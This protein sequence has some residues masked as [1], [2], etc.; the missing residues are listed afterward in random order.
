MR[1]MR[2]V[3]VILVAILVLGVGYAAISNVTLVVDG[4]ATATADPNNF[5]VK[6]DQQSTFSAPTKVPTTATVTQRRI[7]DTHATYS[8]TGFTK[9]GETVTMDFPIVNES[10][11]LNASLSAEVTTHNNDEYFTVSQELSS[12][13]AAAGGSSTLS[14]TITVNKTPITQDETV[15][16][17]VTVT[18]TPVNPTN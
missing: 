13:T 1:K 14:V 5:V 17:V 11:T 7:D 15:R 9:A 16:G 2:G 3:L 4:N 12:P 8:I 10:D 6:F 18:A